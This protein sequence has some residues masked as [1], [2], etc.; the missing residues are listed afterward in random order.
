MNSNQSRNAPSVHGGD[1]QK[2]ANAAECSAALNLACVAD[3]EAGCGGRRHES[4]VCMATVA[5]IS[6]PAIIFDQSIE[7]ND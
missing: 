6:V 2:H 5:R 1:G 4:R 3:C 7:W